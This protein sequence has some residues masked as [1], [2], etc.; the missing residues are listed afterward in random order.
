MSKV[1][2]NE[3]AQLEE[4]VPQKAESVPANHGTPDIVTPILAA[5]V[6][7]EDVALGFL[8]GAAPSEPDVVRL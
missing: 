2:G 8:K 7:N 1:E 3:T 5:H 4:K 6:D